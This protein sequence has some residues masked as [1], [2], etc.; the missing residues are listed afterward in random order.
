MGL[1]HH[2]IARPQFQDE[3]NDLQIWRATSY[4]ADKGWYSSVSVEHGANC[5]P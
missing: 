3:G 4:T 2:R 1:V 5:S